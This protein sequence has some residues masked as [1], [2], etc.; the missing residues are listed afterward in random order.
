MQSRHGFPLMLVLLLWT[1]VPA[2]AQWTVTPFLGINLAG[3]LEFRRGGPGVSVGFLGDRL[4][5]EIDVERY[6][7][8]F[9][10]ADVAE[11]I[12]NNCGVGTAGGPGQPCTDAN[13]DALGFLGSVVAPLR[14]SGGSDWRPYA[15]AGLGVI[16][17][18]VTDPSHQ[19][20]DTGQTNFAASFGGGVIYSA[21]RRVGLRGDLRYI[22]AFVDRSAQEAVLFEDYGFL[23]ATIGVTFTFS[24]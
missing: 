2:Q 15:T 23:R 13:T 3:D 11:V 18:W 16:R 22:R 14:I 4:G 8:F 17:G 7:H 20:A 19:L 10:D 9:R 5:F 12:P 6:N 21:K 1:A 24:R